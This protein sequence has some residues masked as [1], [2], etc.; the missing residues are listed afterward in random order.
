MAYGCRM[1]QRDT[2]RASFPLLRRRRADG[3]H[4]VL[5]TGGIVNS[6]SHA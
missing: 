4:D 5:E 3:G 1:P 2:V 6:G